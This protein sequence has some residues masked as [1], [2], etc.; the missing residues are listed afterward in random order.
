MYGT[1]R[2]VRRKQLDES[3]RLASPGRKRAG[4]PATRTLLLLLGGFL[5]IVVLRAAA[6]DSGAS[7]KVR[8][9]S[10]GDT[11]TTYQGNKLTVYSWKSQS[12]SSKT[13][14]SEIDVESCRTSRNQPLIKAGAFAL[15][16]PTG[17]TFQP[18]GSDLTVVENCIKGKIFFPATRSEKPRSIVFTGGSVRLSWTVDHG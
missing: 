17:K 1:L 13:A 12:A 18:E 15:E 9:L 7:V 2:P 10:L 8:R 14:L 16:M 5:A 11:G 3:R 6:V 4:Q